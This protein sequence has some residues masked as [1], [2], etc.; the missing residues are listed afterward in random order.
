MH[1]PV[2]WGSNRLLLM[3]CYGRK[4]LSPSE[5]LSVSVELA[6]SGTHESPLTRYFCQQVKPGQVIVELGAHIGYFTILLGQLTGPTGKLFALE[7]HPRCHAFLLDN[8]SINY[9]HDRVQSYRLAAFSR[10]SRIS[11]KLNGRNRP[12]Y[13]AGS[14]RVPLFDYDRLIAT[15][16]RLYISE[17][18][19]FFCVMCN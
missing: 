12:R 3:T 13:R 17:Y 8:L 2:Y 1:S 7:P 18:A 4:L 14:R 19:Y 5:D 16:I 15:Q 9:F 10:K 11:R 6:A